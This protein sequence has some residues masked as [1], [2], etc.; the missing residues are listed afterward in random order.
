M[1]GMGPA[2]H[3][4][5]GTPNQTPPCALLTLSLHSIANGV[6]REAEEAEDV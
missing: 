2:F 1:T 3:P 4:P 5:P 6:R